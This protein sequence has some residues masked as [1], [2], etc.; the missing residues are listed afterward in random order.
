VLS[1]YWNTTGFHRNENNL[2]CWSNN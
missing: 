2:D 1:E